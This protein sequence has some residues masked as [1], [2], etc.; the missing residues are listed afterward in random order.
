VR[1]PEDPTTRARVVELRRRLAETKARLD[2]GRW[3]DAVK[4]GTELAREARTVGYHPL[5]AEVLAVVGVARQ[6]LAESAEGVQGA[7]QALE[8]AFWEADA[9]RDDDVRVEAATNL[10]WSVG[11]LQSKFVE[12]DRWIRTAQAVLTRMGG[13]DLQRAWLLNNQGSVDEV[14]GKKEEALRAHEEALALKAKA[15]GSADHPDVG[16]S[17]GNIAVVL[18]DLGRNQEALAHVDRAITIGTHGLGAEHPDVAVQ[19]S[20]RGEILNALGRYRDARQSFERARITWEREL[21]LD[22]RN[23]AYALTGIGESYLAER[24]AV[25]AV[26]PL[27][28]AWKIRAAKEADPQRRGETLFALARALWDSERDRARA[29]TLGREARDAYAKTEVKAKLAEVEAW[30]AQRKKS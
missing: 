1:P 13:H 23:L 29:E 12:S 8:E 28:R 14:Q 19:M 24:D 26:M 5:M 10:V 7:V 9:S 6:K 17:E 11:Y 4:E 18:Q 25:S 16:I 30:L 27:E 2:A 21:G 15:W 20:N 22:A 3:R